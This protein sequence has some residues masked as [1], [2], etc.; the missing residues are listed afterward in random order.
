M[1]EGKYHFYPFPL[2]NMKSLAWEKFFVKTKD[3]FLDK[4]NFVQADGQGIRPKHWGECCF[5]KQN[6]H[7]QRVIEEYKSVKQQ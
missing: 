6:C 1:P 5:M 3:F 7:L 2:T 4:N